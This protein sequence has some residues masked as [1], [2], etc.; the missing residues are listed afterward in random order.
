MVPEG[1]SPPH[2]DFLELSRRAYEA[3]ALAYTPGPP[4]LIPSFRVWHYPAAG[5]LVSWVVFQCRVG[6]SRAT[7]PIVRRT[8]WDRDSDLERLA[9]QTR[10]RPRLDPTLATKEAELEEGRLARFVDEASKLAVPR[11]SVK[12]PYVSEQR[13]EFGLEGYDVE[14]RDG[15]PRVRIEWDREPSPRLWPIT[16][17]AR[18]V[19]DW[20]RVSLP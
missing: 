20:L 2:R 7:N 14:G 9:I 6:V 16:E 11:G 13:L 1:E 15:R 19:R 12:T 18:Q 5:P 8:T 17:W 4:E 3:F 10:R